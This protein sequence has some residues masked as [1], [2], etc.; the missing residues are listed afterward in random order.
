MRH[1]KK[2]CQ[3]QIETST[4]EQSL[5]Q[6]K[7]RRQIQTFGKYS[8]KHIWALVYPTSPQNS[9][10][11]VGFKNCKSTFF[12]SLMQCQNNNF[13]QHQVRGISQNLDHFCLS[14]FH[15]CCFSAQWMIDPWNNKGQT[16]RYWYYKLHWQ[17]TK[18]SNKAYNHFHNPVLCN[19]QWA[20]CP[21]STSAWK[22]DWQEQGLGK[23]QSLKWQL[24]A[25]FFVSKLSTPNVFLKRH[26]ERK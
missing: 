26:F 15:N 22:L 25:T 18:G 19:I 7:L 23:T 9:E 5:P 21:I 10:I 3:T 1:N 8:N 16:V 24:R 20:Y 4:L 13:K 11:S 6:K 12:T 14:Y 17:N 2:S